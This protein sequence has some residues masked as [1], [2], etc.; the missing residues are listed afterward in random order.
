MI[1]TQVPAR[2][3]V[4][5]HRT[6]WPAV[7]V[8]GDLDANTI[9]NDSDPAPG[10]IRRQRR[11][12]SARR[13]RDYLPATVAP[14]LAW[15]SIVVRRKYPRVYRAAWTRDAQSFK[16][17]GTLPTAGSWVGRSSGCDGKL[18]QGPLV[19]AACLVRVDTPS[20]ATAGDLT[21]R[22]AVAPGRKDSDGLAPRYLVPVLLAKTLL[23]AVY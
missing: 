20:W 12:C 23:D 8:F 6:H 9:D 4:T 2:K 11:K 10:G 19:D 1:V 16:L 21:T 3:H 7:V 5:S 17:Q 22:M 18:Q 15:L 13:T 14:R